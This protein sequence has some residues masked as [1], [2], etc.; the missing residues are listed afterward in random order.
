LTI[1]FANPDDGN[2]NEKLHDHYRKTI[3]RL[4]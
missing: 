3:E 2:D 1:K 4:R